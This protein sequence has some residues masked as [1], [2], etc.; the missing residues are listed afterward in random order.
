MCP[1]FY[2]QKSAFE[3]AA[4]RDGKLGRDLPASG[5]APVT[6]IDTTNRQMLHISCVLSVRYDSSA[7]RPRAGGR[8]V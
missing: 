8:T 6:I 2:L 7:I 3:H 4:T 5:A 1:Q